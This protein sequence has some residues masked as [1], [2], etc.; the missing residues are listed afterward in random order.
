MSIVIKVSLS[1]FKGGVGRPTRR[2]HH[3][4]T[5]HAAHATH[6]V[7]SPRSR[8]RGRLCCRKSMTVPD[9]RALAPRKRAALAQ[10]SAG[11][12]SIAVPPLPAGTYTANVDPPPFPPRKATLVADQL[13]VTVCWGTVSYAPLCSSCSP[14]W[15]TSRTCPTPHAPFSCGERVGSS[16][17]GRTHLWP[18]TGSRGA[19]R[20]QAGSG[21]C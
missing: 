13:A 19:A 18:P 16:R 15:I 3:H 1:H 14:S 2:A 21:E 8:R 17:Y 5:T 10:R 11:G 9:K 12:G 6:A 20:G 7:A 4:T